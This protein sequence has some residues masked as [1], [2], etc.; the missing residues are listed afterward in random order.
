MWLLLAGLPCHVCCASFPCH[1]RPGVIHK[2]FCPFPVSNHTGAGFEEVVMAV[3]GLDGLNILFPSPLADACTRAF[4]LAR[5]PTV[6]L[7]RHLLI[8]ASTLSLTYSR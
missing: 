2:D 8:P 4:I 5:H 6:N 3:A 1:S 7:L